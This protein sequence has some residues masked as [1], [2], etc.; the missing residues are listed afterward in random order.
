[1][2]IL[3]V[4]YCVLCIAILGSVSVG[5]AFYA[6]T[7]P[8]TNQPAVYAVAE[9]VTLRSEPRLGGDNKNAPTVAFEQRLLIV[10]EKNEWLM[11][12]VPDQ[13]LRGWVHRAAV[14]SS[15]SLPKQMEKLG[16]KATT[17]LFISG[18][19]DTGTFQ[20]SIVEGGIQ[21]GTKRLLA[22]HGACVVMADA[23]SVNRVGGISMK[24]LGVDQVLSSPDPWTLY[25]YSSAEDKFRSVP[26]L[27]KV[28]KT[29]TAGDQRPKEEPVIAVAKQR[30]AQ[31]PALAEELAGS[32]P[33]RI[34]NPNS[35]SVKVALRSGGKGKDLAVDPNN[36]NTVYVPDGRYDIFFQYSDDPE[37]LYQGD[38]FTLS[39]NGVEIQ[40]VKVVGGDYGIR[41]IR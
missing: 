31:W 26:S 27:V 2:K 19:E 10:E 33:V 23:D 34:R 12:E 40:L 38:S 15:E 20:V 14:S 39:G 17:I 18:I 16:L 41:K 21:L 32:N 11:V 28:G 36:N 8:K 3:K 35:T 9:K 22:E 24:G 13:K 5:I 25:F 1:M 30:K 29:V 7:T 6:Q 37:G 4:A